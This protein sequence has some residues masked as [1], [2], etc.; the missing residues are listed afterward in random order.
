MN[1]ILFLDCDGVVCTAR[2]HYAYGEEGGIWNEWDPLAC[3]V[4]RRCCANGVQIVVSSTWRKG[5]FVKYFHE[6]RRKHDLDGYCFHN[7]WATPVLGKKRHEE[8]LAWLERHPEI[9]DYKVL[10][11]DPDIIHLPANKIIL[12]DPD[13]GMLSGHIKRLLNW[14]G[15]LKA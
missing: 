13:D 11:D 15:V 3:E 1:K 14:A 9:T 2:S 8:I 6:Q 12:T 7:D 4:L 10:D 5:Q